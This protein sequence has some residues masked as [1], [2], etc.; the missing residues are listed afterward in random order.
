[1]YLVKV[2]QT[3]PNLSFFSFIYDDLTSTLILKSVIKG[4]IK[5]SKIGLKLSNFLKF[6]IS[7]Q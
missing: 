2:F 5:T 3:G 4:R 7:Y 6:N 1:M